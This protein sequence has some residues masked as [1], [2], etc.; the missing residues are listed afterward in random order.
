[1]KRDIAWLCAPAVFS[2][3]A[4]EIADVKKPGTPDE[5]RKQ[6]PGGFHSASAGCR[7]EDEEGKLT[8]DRF[9]TGLF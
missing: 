2:T 8:V 4:I 3:R 5:V 7:H 1:M 9:R 6:G